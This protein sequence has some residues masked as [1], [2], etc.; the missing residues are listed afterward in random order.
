[1]LSKQNRDKLQ[2]IIKKYNFCQQSPYSES[3]YTEGEITWGS[4]PEGSLRLSD[5]WNF[6]SEGETH[7][8][9]DST[10]E[11]LQKWLVCEYHNGTYRIVEE[12]FTAEEE[13]REA[14]L[15]AKRKNLVNA[16][17]QARKDGKEGTKEFK[18][19]QDRMCKPSTYS[20]EL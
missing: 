13:A 8:K 10:S 7:C 9:L 14:R 5:H 6:E 19:L 2:K 4:K 1:M 3:F 11:Y 20:I 15:I 18:K 17:V 12:V 16:Y